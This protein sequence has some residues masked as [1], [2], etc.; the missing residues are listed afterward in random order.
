MKNRVEENNV[1]KLYEWFKE[2][3]SDE[4]KRNLFLYMDF[5]MKY[6][7]DRGYCI[8]TFNPNEIEIL[9]NSIKQVKF[10]YLYKM[11]EDD[12]PYQEKLKNEDIFNSSTV[13]ILLYSK[14]PMMIN[15]DYL[16]EHF[17]EFTTFLPEKDVPYYRGVIERGASVYFAEYEL[18]R[19]KRENDTLEKE[20]NE[21]EGKRDYN[22]TLYNKNNDL[23]KMFTN[24]KINN[25]IYK[26][27]NYI[28]E[29]AFINVLLYP[30]IA[31]VLALVYTFVSFLI[32]HIWL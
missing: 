15:V 23:S 10:N 22:T 24:D 20:L 14:L 18:E 2:P 21:L 31:I 30:T 1:I 8:A 3:H 11:P 16:K 19:V 9:N 6:V 26:K 25:S 5:A 32:K 4:E 12:I 29:S 27:I 7:H 13:Q 17:D 28:Q